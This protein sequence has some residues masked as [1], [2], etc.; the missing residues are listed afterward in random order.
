MDE[1]CFPYSLP[2]RLLTLGANVLDASVS[3]EAVQSDSGNFGVVSAALRASCMACA[4][5]ADLSSS[6]LPAVGRKS[7]PIG[8]AMNEIKMS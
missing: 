3:D 8:Y 7:V 4:A 5:I 2:F 6:N 1:R